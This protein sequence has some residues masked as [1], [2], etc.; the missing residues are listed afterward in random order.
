MERCLEVIRTENPWGVIVQYGGQTPL[1]LAKELAQEG[2][3]IIGHFLM[4]LMQLKIVSA[5]KKL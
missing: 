5:F 1:K 3:P 4:I 2:A